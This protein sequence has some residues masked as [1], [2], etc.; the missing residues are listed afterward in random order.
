MSKVINIMLIC[1]LMLAGSVEAA[2]QNNTASR[3]RLAEKFNNAVSAQQE[4]ADNGAL[5]GRYVKLVEDDSFA[6]YMDKKSA[7]WIL[8][9]NSRDE[10][11]IDVWIRLES[12]ENDAATKYSYPA[13]YYLEHYYLRPDKQQIQFLCELEV[14]GRPD[15]NVNQRSYDENNWEN[16]VPESVEDVIYQNVVKKIKK[17]NAGFWDIPV[18]DIMEDWFRISI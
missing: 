14:T 2:D 8:C 5:N 10:Y 15:N 7:K 9:P 1:L 17:R 13:K 6:Y 4:Q 3:N 12:V 16:L 11:I 18:G